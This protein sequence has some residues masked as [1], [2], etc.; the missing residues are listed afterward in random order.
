MPR[1][2]VVAG[3]LLQAGVDDRVDAWERSARSRR[4]WFATMTR[5]C[6]EG[7][8]AR[9]CASAS[10][11]PC[12]GTTSTSPRTLCCSSV[13]ARRISAPRPWQETQ[14]V[15]I[16]RRQRLER[17]IGHR[18]AGWIGHLDRMRAAGH[19]DDRAT[20]E[21]PRHPLRFERRRHDDDA[22][23]VSGAPGLTRERKREVGVDAA[24]VKLVEDD[25]GEIGE[26]PEVA[27]AGARSARPR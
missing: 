18:L 1:F 25:G 12:S 4:C 9:S 22:E 7:R 6:D 5:R 19:V 16:G 27:L 10:S 15:T 24:L 17:R 21:K 3:D 2:G 23:V 14:H 26:Q 20:V 13:T 8:S 11:E